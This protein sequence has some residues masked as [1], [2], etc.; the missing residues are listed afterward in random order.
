MGNYNTPIEIW[1]KN[2]TST[3]NEIGQKISSPGMVAEFFAE[4]QSK[5]GSMMYGR[6]AG[7]K[8]SKTTHKIIY[9]Y[10]NFP[11]LNDKH[12]I[13]IDG[14]KY[15]IDFCDNRNNTNEFMDVFVTKEG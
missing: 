2:V 8:L 13:V 4:V 11:E 15:S 12:L 10:D 7:T 9:I 5:S 3:K 6:P 1:S 14:K